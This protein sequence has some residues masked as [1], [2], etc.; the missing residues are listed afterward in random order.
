MT[1][2]DLACVHGSIAFVL[3]NISLL[4]SS[5]FYVA[6]YCELN[7]EACRCKAGS[8]GACV[9]SAA[10]AFAERR[11]E[12]GRAIHQLLRIHMQWRIAKICKSWWAQRHGEHVEREPITRVQGHSPWSGGKAFGRSMGAANLSTF[13][14]FGDR[15][16]HLCRLANGGHRTMPPKFATVHVPQQGPRA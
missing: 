9:E 10:I 5:T 8:G 12:F 6:V 1:M 13:L 14:K 4:F 16:P 3:D 7:I 11:K 15:K 2:L